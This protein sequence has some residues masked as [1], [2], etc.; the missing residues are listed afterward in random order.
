MA[1]SLVYI[2][3][4]LHFGS[5]RTFF[6]LKWTG[7]NKDPLFIGIK[8]FNYTFN[9]QIIIIISKSYKTKLSSGPD[10]F[11]CLADFGPCALCLTLFSVRLLFFCQ[12]KKYMSSTSCR[13][14]AIDPTCVLCMDC[15]QDS[16]HKSHRYKVGVSINVYI[17]NGFQ[18]F[19]VDGVCTNL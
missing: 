6:D 18:Q 7:P 13:D 17:F 2:K 3:L 16:V 8:K 4:I 9:P 12:V 11:V 1:S 10:W 5:H 14:C 15:F 19:L